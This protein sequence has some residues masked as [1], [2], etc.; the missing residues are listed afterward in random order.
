MNDNTIKNRFSLIWGI[1][2]ALS[3]LFYDLISFIASILFKVLLDR[4]TQFFT[5]SFIAHSHAFENALGWVHRSQ[6]KN[7]KK[8]LK[9]WWIIRWQETFPLLISAFSGINRKRFEK[10][11]SKLVFFPWN[12]V[13]QWVFY[14]DCFHLIFI[15]AKNPAMTNPEPRSW[16]SF[17]FSLLLQNFIIV[18]PQLKWLKLPEQWLKTRVKYC[19]KLINS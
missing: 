16:V 9:I 17:F 2:S 15:F 8:V 13:R 6:H 1:A 14:H 4:Y 10:F 11:V 19:K 3:T 12:R 18:I 7:T 5:D